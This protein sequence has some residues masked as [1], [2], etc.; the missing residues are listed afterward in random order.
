G[1]VSSLFARD[2][3]Y[4]FYGAADR[5]EIVRGPVPFSGAQSLLRVHVAAQAPI[6]AAVMPD[7]LGP[8]DIEVRLV[9]TLTPPRRVVGT[10]VQWE[11]AARLKK[12][13]YVLPPPMLRGHQVALTDRGI[14]LIA[15]EGVDVIP[16]GTLL[17]EV[18]PGLYIPLGMD[19]IPRVP[20]EVLAAAVE[21]E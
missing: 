3:L 17:C 12:V 8:V 13:V 18:A 14:L 10:L 4:L 7:R 11:D 6:A 19:I 16:L 9:P 5:L 20:T 1:S 21:H 15:A 2:R